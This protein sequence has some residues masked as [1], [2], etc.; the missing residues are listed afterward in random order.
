MF[1]YIS[2]MAKLQEYLIEKLSRTTLFEMAL[3]RADYAR[4]SS[5][6]T[7]QI[8][9]N[10]CLIRY[11]TLYDPTNQNKTHWK[12]ELDSYCYRLF[13]TV[14]KNDKQRILKQVWIG[15]NELN[16]PENVMQW[17]Q[18]K[19]RIEHINDRQQQERVCE[20]FSNQLEHIIYLISGKNY[21][22][23]YRYIDEDI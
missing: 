6:M 16:Q 3:D 5:N 1:L 20:D 13:R 4:L 18:R 2:Y 17:M 19:F 10:W 15:D 12:Q 23:L 14:T 11:C 7:E 9:E 22:E 21:Q 8:V